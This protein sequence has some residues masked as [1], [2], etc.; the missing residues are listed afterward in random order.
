MVER[1]ATNQLNTEPPPSGERPSVT[2]SDPAP[3]QANQNA[4]DDDAGARPD[5]ELPAFTSLALVAVHEI[6]NVLGWLE[7]T[8]EIVERAEE[9]RARGDMIS[10]ADLS[11][12]IRDARLGVKH[13]SSIVQQLRSFGRT[14]SAEPAEFDPAQALAAA[15]RFSEARIARRAR[16]R[17]GI[18][19]TPLVR[20]SQHELTCVFLNLLLNAAEAIEERSP[21]ANVINVSSSTDERGWASFEVEDSGRGIAPEVGEHVFDAY[22]TGRAERGGTGLGL[23]VS[24]RIVRAM[25]GEIG[26]ESA[27]G[28]GSLF[29]VVIP[30]AHH[31][32]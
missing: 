27:P 6:S 11:P 4:S 7:M 5:A 22:F 23:H 32:I 19:R 25:G 3:K 21:E 31:T 15:I 13:M 28:L 14:A 29:R 24:R 16:L 10:P 18:G 9:G 12:T 2:H 26:F 17:L 8:L 30:A 20:G 1:D